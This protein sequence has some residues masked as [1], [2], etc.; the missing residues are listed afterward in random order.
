[1][2]KTVSLISS[3]THFLSSFTCTLFFIIV[4]CVL[5]MYTLFH[6]PTSSTSLFKITKTPLYFQDIFLSSSDNYT[7]SEYLRALTL[8]P[9]V[10]GTPSSLQTLDYVQ[11]QFQDLGLKTHTVEFEALLSYPV[12]SS[13][14]L[15]FNDGSVQNLVLTEPGQAGR[16]IDPY[17]AYSPSGS[18]FAKVVYGNYGREEDYSM[19]VRLGVKVKGCVVIVRRGEVS[20]G[21]VVRKAQENG[22]VG[23]FIYVDGDN[24]DGVERGTVM[25]GLGD[26]LTP[27]WTGVKGGEK[28][29]FDDS[30]VLKRFPKIPSMPI[31]F[32]NAEVIL[33]SLDG[34]NLPFEW[35]DNLQFKFGSLGVGPTLVNFTYQEENK[36]AKVY[37]IFAVLRGW[38][39]PDRYVLLGNHRDAWTY[40]AVDPN[41]GT[42][43]LLDIARRYALLMRSGWAP[44]RTIVLCS[45]DAEEF[46]MV[47]STEWVEQNLVN[48]GSKAAVYLN[49]DCAVQ[50]EGFFA[51]ATPQLDNLIIEVTKKASEIT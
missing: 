51:R 22:A 48:L 29:G 28:L 2:A 46:G 38:E 47:G 31:S 42:A 36:L 5:A 41:S 34:V 43:A 24:F 40:G 20:R 18:A 30:E 10:T 25:R 6:H 3:P 50:G 44:R 37:N 11:T 9:H 27:G 21:G 16:V 12:H 23:V 8:H 26:P 39:E 33:K 1:M 15:H 35:R 14:S 13:V 4:L 45:W 17:H 32:T 19:L 7:L 49:V